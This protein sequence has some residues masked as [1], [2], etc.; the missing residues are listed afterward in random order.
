MPILLG[1][2]PWL[3]RLFSFPF[4]LGFLGRL[5]SALSLLP[6]DGVAIHHFCT[7]GPIN[8]PPHRPTCPQVRYRPDLPLV[9]KGVS[10]EVRGGEK[11]G[12]VGRT[13]SG[14][15]TLVSALFRLVEPCS[16]SLRIDGLD[17]L[18]LGLADLRSRLAI[19]PQD[20]TLFSGTVR[21]NLD[22]ADRHT[23]EE[24]WEVRRGGGGC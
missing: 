21:Y 22:P 6:L 1:V 24:I 5:L 14:K 15:S 18:A 19:I 16:G 17:C 23:D 20:P 2:T 3:G 12:I 7:F 8:P 13:G 4:L 9:L 11:A 10:L